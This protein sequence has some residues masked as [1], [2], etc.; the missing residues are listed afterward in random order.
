[1]DGTAAPAGERRDKGSAK[2]LAPR[3]QQTNSLDPGQGVVAPGRIPHIH[4]S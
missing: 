1:M 2:L 4:A 3:D